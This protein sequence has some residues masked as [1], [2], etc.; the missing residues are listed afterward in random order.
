MPNP[1]VPM[2]LWI[3]KPL[4]CLP[5]RASASG[6]ASFALTRP[7]GG[8]TG[9]DSRPAVALGGF[10]PWPPAARAIASS[11]SSRASPPP[12]PAG[13][14]PGSAAFLPDGGFGS[15]G[16]FSG[17][18]SALAGAAFL[19]VGGLPPFCCRE[20]AAR[21]ASASAGAP[22]PAGDPLP[23]AGPVV[24]AGLGGTLSGAGGG[25]VAAVGGVG[26]PSPCAGGGA[27]AAV[28]S[29]CSWAAWASAG[30]H[31]CPQDRQTAGVA[32]CSFAIL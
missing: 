8:L 23:S 12:D 27:A 6:P 15:D 10:A 18:V 30:T 28:G 7:V 1:P 22:P 32:R 11:A 3:L 20:A 14:F 29:P 2:R 24:W 21:A 16:G 26:L 31:R 5:M 17:D 25:C 13:G 19:G 9:A 4:T